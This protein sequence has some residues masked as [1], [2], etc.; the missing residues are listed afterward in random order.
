MASYGTFEPEPEQHPVPRA[1]APWKV[2]AESYMLFLKLNELPE[3]VYDPLEEAWADEGLGSFV[4]GL[5]AVMIVRYS[6]TP[7]GS[8][9]ELLLIPG[10][11]TVPQPPLS[12]P[13]LPL[14]PNIIPKTAHRI[15]RIYV[16]QLTTAY[17][18]R[19]NWNIPKHLAR[20]S[21]SAPPTL[22]SDQSFLPPS[23]PQA[24]T[25]QVFPPGTHDGDGVPP[26]FAATLTPW[27]WVPSFPAN[28]RLLPMWLGAVQPP[29]PAAPGFTRATAEEEVGAKDGVVIGE[30]DVDPRM[31]E[32]V[33][34]GTER[35]CGFTVKAKVKRARGCWVQIHDTE[36]MEEEE[37]EE[38]EEG[39]GGTW[40]PG[41]LGAWR[42][43]GWF[44]EGDWEIEEGVGWQ[45]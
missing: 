14:P 19:L 1:K 4:G 38:E 28:T 44:E 25:V 17:N 22:T 27:K 24:L 29:V 9:D 5:G 34:V 33:L 20:F 45:L 26:F 10:T 16:S 43:G 18:G 2:K 40:F 41:V 37:E 7:V 42:V 35:W 6:D 8:Y 21:F 39:E 13:P 31:E 30:Y 12:S 23:P 15:S 32:N 11:F 3:G 36:K